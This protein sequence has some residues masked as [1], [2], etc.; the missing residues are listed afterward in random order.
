LN[1]TVASLAVTML[2]SA[3][4]G[5]P[6]SARHQL[7]LFNRGTVRAAT[8]DPLPQCVVC[9]LQGVLGRG[10]TWPMPGRPR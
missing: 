9:S 5:L 3:V 10:D 2:L 7:V 1:A 6:L 4:A 8:S